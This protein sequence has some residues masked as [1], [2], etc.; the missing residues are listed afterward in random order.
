MS[1]YIEYGSFEEDTKQFIRLLHGFYVPNYE[2]VRDFMWEI[3][4]QGVEDGR[5]SNGTQEV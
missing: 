3:Y 5:N 2:A 1:E 4:K